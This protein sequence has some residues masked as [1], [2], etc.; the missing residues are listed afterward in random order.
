MNIFRVYF[1]ALLVSSGP[2]LACTTSVDVP[3]MLSDWSNRQP[4]R[5]LEGEISMT[6]AECIR[7][8]FQQGLVVRAGK[9]VGYKLGLTNA[10][11]QKALGHDAPISGALMASMLL[12]DGSELPAQFG[13]RPLMEADLLVEVADE[14]INEAQSPA[15][16][17]QHL[18]GV[19]PFIEL[20]DLLVDP[21]VKING[22]RLVALNVGARLGIVG[23]TLPA[24]PAQLDALAAMT[25]VLTDENG[26]V[27]AQGHGSDILGH[28][29]NAVIWLAKDLS[30]HG[31][32][33]KKGDLISLGSF[34]APLKPLQGQS[35][36]VSYQGLP[37]MGTASVR[38]K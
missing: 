9:Q 20:P 15:E 21:Q 16:V 22:A 18:S 38:F 25:V 8:E 2:L 23:K 17:I 32:R 24:S 14:G 4:V 37:G 35:V 19:I 36:T 34:N 31:Q 29:L 12:P 33:L 3:R 26:K 11:V 28:P 7:T 10:N 5:G 1:L 13:T 6:E 27:L 30:R